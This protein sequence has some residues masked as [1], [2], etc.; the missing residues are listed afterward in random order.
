MPLRLLLIEHKI[1][2]LPTIAFIGSIQIR[3][4]YDDHGT[5]HF[6]AVSPDFDVKIAIDD[7]SVISA[8]GR[9]RG[10]DVAA[11]R[12]WGRKHRDVLYANWQFAREGKP[13]RTIED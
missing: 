1:S 7:C 11:I 9:L 5:P 12:D 2:T 8:T 4:Y 13:L 6:H 3:I 10:R